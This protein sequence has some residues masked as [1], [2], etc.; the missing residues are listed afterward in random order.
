MTLAQMIATFE[1][2]HKQ[3]KA[4]HLAKKLSNTR[5]QLQLLL[6]L[7]AKCI[8]FFKRGFYYEHRDKSG[9]FLARALKMLEQATTILDIKNNEGKPVQKTD[10]IAA[11]FHDYYIKLYNLPISHKP[12]GTTWI[13]EQL[14]KIISRIVV[15]QH[16]PLLKRSLWRRP[17]P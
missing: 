5:E 1:A 12:A 15:C 9:K 6:N 17:L 14:L 11:A 13:R 2:Q 8:L 10:Q 3:S 16:C 4:E 7:K